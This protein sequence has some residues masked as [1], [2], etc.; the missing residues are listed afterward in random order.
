MCLLQS[1]FQLSCRATVVKKVLI[2]DLANAIRC[3]PLQRT[4]TCCRMAEIQAGSCRG[5]AQ[6]GPPMRKP[7]PVSSHACGTAGALP[8]ALVTEVPFTFC[9]QQHTS[10]EQAKVTDHRSACFDRSELIV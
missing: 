10:R 6:K 3:R 2:P 4:C 8:G 5:S 7:A 1:R 9:T